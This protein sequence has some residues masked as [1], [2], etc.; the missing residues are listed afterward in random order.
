MISDATVARLFETSSLSEPIDPV[1]LAAFQSETSAVESNASLRRAT[2]HVVVAIICYSLLG[3][4]IEAVVAGIPIMI[5]L[6]GGL[7]LAGV[8]T[9]VI[10]PPGLALILLR[11]L[12]PKVRDEL[13]A[14][15]GWRRRFLLARLALANG[16]RY[17]PELLNPPVF[18]SVFATGRVRYGWDFFESAS[19]QTGSYRTDDQHNNGIAPRGWGFVRIRLEREVPHLLLLPRQTRIYPARMIVAVNNDQIL[20]LEGDFD[21][22]FTLYVPAGYERDALYVMTPDVMA[23]L[24]DNVP[25]SFV[26]MVGNWLTIAFPGPLD[27]AQPESWRRLEAILATI[28]RRGVRQTHRYADDRSSVRG[29]VAPAGQ[30]LKRGIPIAA[31]IGACWIV[32]Q[33]LIHVVH[34]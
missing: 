10:L 26:E 9:M 23:S 5:L 19:F 15:G 25:G 18:A 11:W 28:G 14:Q 8:I 34:F 27:A 31:V 33:I 13:R 29:A 7:P 20:H 21:R 17:R 30:R 6:E 12:A 22:H 16:F 3:L 4:A 1:R 24:I 2:G 32:T